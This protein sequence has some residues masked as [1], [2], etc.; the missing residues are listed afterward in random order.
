MGKHHADSVADPYAIL[1]VPHT[2]SADEI[3]AAF[4][5]LARRLHPDSS[6]NAATAVEFIR[7]RGAY[8]ILKDPVQ[9][10][11]IDDQQERDEQAARRQDFA[12]HERDPP[13]PKPTPQPKSAAENDEWTYHNWPRYAPEPP[14]AAT[15][16]AEDAAE[17]LAEQMRGFGPPPPPLQ[18]ERLLRQHSS[19]RSVMGS[20]RDSSTRLKRV[21]MTHL[22]S[23]LMAGVGIGMMEHDT[24]GI[25]GAVLLLLAPTLVWVDGKWSVRQH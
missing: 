23:L 10:R 22:V 24:W 1:G 11:A 12:G 16:S 21:R 6:R 14:C 7:V 9:R 13:V 25:F 5:T 2:A 18:S 3:K 15:V 8:E 20:L 19:W 4:N 17:I